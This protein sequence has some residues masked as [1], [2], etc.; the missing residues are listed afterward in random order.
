MIEESSFLCDEGVS[1][2]DETLDRTFCCGTSDQ[3]YR[4][5]PSDLTFSLGSSDQTYH[6]GTSDQT[7]SLGSS[8]QTYSLGTSDQTYSLGCSDQTYSLGISDQTYRI[9]T[10]DQTYN[11]DLGATDQ[12]FTLTGDRTFTLSDEKEDRQHFFNETFTKEYVP[13]SR[14][15]SNEYDPS[16]NQSFTVGPPNLQSAA[17]EEE[18][19]EQKR[20]SKPPRPRASRQKRAPRAPAAS[21][22]K[23]NE[24][25]EVF[26]QEEDE[27]KERSMQYASDSDSVGEEEIAMPEVIENIGPAFGAD[28]CYAMWSQPVIVESETET[29]SSESE[30]SSE[31]ETDSDSFYSSCYEDD[32]A[33]NEAGVDTVGVN[34]S[35]EYFWND[36]KGKN[37]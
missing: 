33:N 11:L 18:N 13:A 25:M 9:G 28:N 7:Y 5:G 16:L 8:D 1:A 29:E 6:I 30:S 34:K 15:N 36:S 12:T 23:T 19:F 2:S 14:L 26:N 37:E 20:D 35:Q 22:T 4:I 10:S 27:V 24:N 21:K 31:S 17:E 3:T 32:V